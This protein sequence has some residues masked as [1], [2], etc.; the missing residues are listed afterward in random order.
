MTESKQNDIDLRSDF[1]LIN[2]R[3]SGENIKYMRLSLGMSQRS[4]ANFLNVSHQ[5][6]SNWEQE[7]CRPARGAYEDCV[8]KYLK[9]RNSDFRNPSNYLLF[10]PMTIQY[11]KQLLKGVSTQD[12]ERFINQLK[13]G[14]E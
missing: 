6:V 11:L 7:V 10:N 14:D 2:S 1:D 3:Y 4:F 12:K 9:K 13:D 8:S 5:T